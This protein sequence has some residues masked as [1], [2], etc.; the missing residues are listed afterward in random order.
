MPRAGQD[1]VFPI[2][3]L[4]VEGEAL[5]SSECKILV[6]GTQWR[7]RGGLLQSSHEWY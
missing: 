2:M 4:G 1:G 3:L 7:S 5:R 6:C